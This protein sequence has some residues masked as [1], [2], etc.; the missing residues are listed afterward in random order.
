M[1]KVTFSIVLVSIFSDFGDEDES[2]LIRANQARW[3]RSSPLIIGRQ[4][5]RCILMNLCLWQW[6]VAPSR[7]ELE[8]GLVA[9]PGSQ[10]MW[11]IARSGHGS[12]TWECAR[13]WPVAT[14]A[15]AQATLATRLP[16]TWPPLMR[17]LPRR[18]CW[19]GGQASCL[20]CLA[21]PTHQPPLMR[22]KSVRVIY[23]QFQSTA[24]W[25]DFRENVES[26]LGPFLSFLSTMI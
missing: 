20:E 8:L 21:T 9:C 14:L 11:S 3:L 24:L 16:S 17:P 5:A 7:E 13:C 26:W 12:I 1:W 18:L 4:V 10:D 25:A 19:G 2:S 6:Q 22:S 23:N 15:S